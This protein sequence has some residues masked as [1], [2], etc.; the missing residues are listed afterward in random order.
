MSEHRRGPWPEPLDPDKPPAPPLEHSHRQPRS[1]WIVTWVAV[2]L[3]AVA[4]GLLTVYVVRFN[5]YVQGR[6]Q[7]RDAENQRLQEQIHEGMCDLLDQLPA[8]AVL[9]GPRRKY[10]CGPGI[11]VNDLPPSIRQRWTPPVVAPTTAA[12]TS[13]AP[14]TAAPTRDA[15]APARTTAPVA[16]VPPRPPGAPPSTPSAPPTTVDPLLCGLVKICVEVHR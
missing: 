8:S 4:V 9:D 12:P 6:G 1:P 10:G 2:A 16:T 11:P 13:A 15:S 3:L 7:A 14:T 5:D